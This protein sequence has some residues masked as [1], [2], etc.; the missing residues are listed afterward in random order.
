MFRLEVELLLA[1]NA[2]RQRKLLQ[3]LGGPG[4]RRNDKPVAAI[5]AGGCL[6]HRRFLAEVNAVDTNLI[7]DGCPKTLRLFQ[8]CQDTAASIQKAGLG[9]KATDCLCGQ[10]QCGKAIRYFL[11]CQPLIGPFE[12]LHYAHSFFDVSVIGTCKVEQSGEVQKFFSGE[13]FEFLPEGECCFGELYVERVVIEIAI[14]PRVAMGTAQA[15]PI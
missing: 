11:G 12:R 9:R 14:Y 3:D 13:S 1:R 8:M 4:A 7:M 15:W 2:Q 10:T 5:L 6:K